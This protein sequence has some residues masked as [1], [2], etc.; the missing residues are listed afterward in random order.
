[1]NIN[2]LTL[3]QVQEIRSLFSVPSSP[4]KTFFVLGKKYLIRTVTHYYTGKLVSICEN[5][6]V[7]SDAAWIADTGRFHQAISNGVLD[8][9]EPFD[10]DVI[11]SRGAIVDATEWKHE[12]P[13]NQK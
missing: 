10:S 12:L 9:I 5:E 8:E 7:L 1:M 3:G 4:I 13:R 6:I 11:I 2:E